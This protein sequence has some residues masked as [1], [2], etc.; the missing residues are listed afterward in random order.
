MR[1]AFAFKIVVSF[2]LAIVYYLVTMVF[3]RKILSLMVIGNSQ[4]ELILDQGQEYMFFNGI[5][6][7]TDKHFLYYRF[8][9][10]GDRK[11][12]CT[13]NFLNYCCID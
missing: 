1:Q 6:W 3:T 13:I 5:H 12:K 10:Q 9:L 2:S 7:H 4:A 8:I 11:G